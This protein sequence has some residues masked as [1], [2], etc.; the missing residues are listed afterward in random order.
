MGA[1]AS[2]NVNWDK[3]KKWQ[4]SCKI[5]EESSE[6]RYGRSKKGKV[7]LMEKIRK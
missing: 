7:I 5:A 2:K 3:I 4:M 6:E 1:K